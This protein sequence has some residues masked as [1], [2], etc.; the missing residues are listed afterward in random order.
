MLLDF[1]DG[2]TILVNDFRGLKWVIAGD[3]GDNPLLLA[4][5][6]IALC[7]CTPSAS[8]RVRRGWTS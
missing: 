4:G 2:D 6:V 8:A 7:S 1:D 5:N 3:G